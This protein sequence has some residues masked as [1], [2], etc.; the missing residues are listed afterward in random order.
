MST[1]TLGW[2]AYHHTISLG[3]LVA[4]VRSRAPYGNCSADGRW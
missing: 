1:A 4:V 2:A 3:A